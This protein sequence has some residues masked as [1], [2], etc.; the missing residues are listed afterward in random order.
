MIVKTKFD[1]ELVQGH[2]CICMI[3]PYRMVQVKEDMLVFH[4]RLFQCQM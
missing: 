3:I 2:S 1:V 4:A